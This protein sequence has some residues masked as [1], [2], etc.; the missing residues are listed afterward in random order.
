MKIS[1]QFLFLASGV[2][3]GEGFWFLGVSDSD[4]NVLDN[5]YLLDCHRKELI[6]NESSKDILFAI[7]L[8]INNLLNEL[9][10]QKY[11]L[12]KPSLGISFNIP[13]DVLERIFDF[14]LD[15]YKDQYSWEICIGLL[16]VRKKLSLSNLIN[17]GSLKG[18]SK[19]WAI[20]IEALHNYLP[21]P[22]NDHI[23]KV[24]MWK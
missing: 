18:N 8:N 13:L 4:K 7:N 9:E 12:D 19:K 17:N 6:G 14:W 15:V 5:K 11:F 2:K 24:P 21:N 20:E 3:D 1:N 16:K 23:D 22:V 10:K